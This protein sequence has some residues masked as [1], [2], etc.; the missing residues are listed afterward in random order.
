MH[1]ARDLQ[2]GIAWHLTAYNKQPG[3]GANHIQQG[4]NKSKIRGSST[5]DIIPLLVL[6]LLEYIDPFLLV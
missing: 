5:I 3:A 4:A 1:V 2:R 6:T